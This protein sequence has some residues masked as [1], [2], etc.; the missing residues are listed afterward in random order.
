MLFLGGGGCYRRKCHR[1]GEQ[2][3]NDAGGHEISGCTE[4][5]G[6]YSEPDRGGH[7][8]GCTGWWNIEAGGR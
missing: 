5:N 1:E 3:R 2:I 6:M 4:K 7:T 8:G